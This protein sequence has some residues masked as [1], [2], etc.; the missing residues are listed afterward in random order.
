[1]E[2]HTARAPPSNIKDA[3]RE[4]PLGHFQA[5]VMKL[6]EELGEDAYGFKIE[7]ILETISIDTSQIYSTF[8]KLENRTFLQK[9][10][11]RKSD[12]G[13]PPRKVWKL[14]PK[15]RQAL[16]ETLAHYQAVVLLLQR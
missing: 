12:Q 8:K 15:G 10:G 4:A 16:Q 13:G 14:T 11:E 2:R 3:L 7:K 5:V 1:M 6:V 9:V